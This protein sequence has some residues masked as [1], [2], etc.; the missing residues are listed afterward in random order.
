[1]EL[2]LIEGYRRCFNPSLLDFSRLR[3]CAVTEFIYHKQLLEPGLF[4]GVRYQHVRGD[5]GIPTEGYV[6]FYHPD[7]AY[8]K[9]VK[10]YEESGAAT[11]RIT[12]VG[13]CSPAED[14]SFVSCV[15]CVSCSLE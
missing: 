3:M 11:R 13:L 1:M 12:K 2:V 14:V 8:T 4:V 6:F 5:A 10:L 15:T 9:H 7:R